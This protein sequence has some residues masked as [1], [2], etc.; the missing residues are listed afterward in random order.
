MRR[1][2]LGESRRKHLHVGIQLSLKPYM[3]PF[4][5]PNHSM[6]EQHCN[7]IH[8]DCGQVVS[9]KTKASPAE[10]GIFVLRK[11]FNPLK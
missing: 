1:N 9:K 4:R 8:V 3:S 11:P 5:Y 7:D 2:C 10:C 6:Y